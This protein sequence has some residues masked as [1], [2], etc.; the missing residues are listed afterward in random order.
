MSLK[1]FGTYLSWSLAVAGLFFISYL[2]LTHLNNFR[3]FIISLLYAGTIS[4]SIYLCFGIAEHLM[5]KGKIQVFD[6]KKQAIT[7]LI[8]LFIGIMMTEQAK[9]MIFKTSFQWQQIPNIF[10]TG[11]FIGFGILYFQFY[12]NEQKENQELQLINEQLKKGQEQ[13][14]QT[15]L[16]NL[17]TKIGTETKVIPVNE[18]I[19]FYSKDHYTYG[20]TETSEVILDYSLKSLVEK[21]NPKDF[22]QTHRS[23]IVAKKSIESI[24]KESRWKIKTHRGDVLDVSR[25]NQKKLKEFLLGQ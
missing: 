18:F 13:N 23:T 1:N 22:L 12:R 8:G 25:G 24:S 6:L 15:F 16:T 19:Y 17:S 14:R 3:S 11:S 9:A 20:V 10:L 4:C 21:L 5:N 7:M 2:P